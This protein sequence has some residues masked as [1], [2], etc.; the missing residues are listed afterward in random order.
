MIASGADGG[1][2][3]LFGVKC[4]NKQNK[5]SQSGEGLIMLTRN[6]RSQIAGGKLE[7]YILKTKR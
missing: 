2:W 4:I 6:V 7:K 3:M 1:A 5:L